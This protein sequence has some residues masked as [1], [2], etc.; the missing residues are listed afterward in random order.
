[1]CVCKK[2]NTYS[3]AAEHQ[4]LVPGKLG[5]LHT[6]QALQA[7]QVMPACIGGSISNS[8][9]FHAHRCQVFLKWFQD[10]CVTI[11]NVYVAIL[12]SY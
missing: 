10:Q 7:M 6:K 11:I 4:S 9:T 1:M 2:Q 3:L 5:P 8:A 12:T